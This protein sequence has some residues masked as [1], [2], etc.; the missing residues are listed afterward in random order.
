MK[1]RITGIERTLQRLD[2][3]RK[4]GPR[5]VLYALYEFGQRVMDESQ[6]HAPVQTG[7]LKASAYVSHPEQFGGE[8]RV[9]VGYGADHAVA[10][11]ETMSGRAPK[12]LEAAAL[13]QAKGK[14]HKI[15]KMAEDMIEQG[16]PSLPP[17]RYPY[18]P[19]GGGS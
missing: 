12:Y 16:K 19:N 4:A 11:H 2:E 10:Q 15:A 13:S 6:K 18:T 7:E 8:E 3:V 9:E 17:A 1:L 14:L 5:A